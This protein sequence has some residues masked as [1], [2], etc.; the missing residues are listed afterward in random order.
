MD[1]SLGSLPSDQPR[2][3]SPE[4][5]LGDSF[6]LNEFGEC[7]L[8]VSDFLARLVHPDRIVPTVHNRNTVRPA[9]IAAAAMNRHGT[10]KS[11]SASPNV[12]TPRGDRFD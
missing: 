11:P 12:D 5:S 9:I 7:P 2:G 4:S 10:V 8:A 6:H 1:R 3:I